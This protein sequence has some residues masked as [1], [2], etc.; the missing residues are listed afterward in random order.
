MSQAQRKAL[1]GQMSPRLGSHRVLTLNEGRGSFGRAKI[2]R[3]GYMGQAEG[4]RLHREA[5]ASLME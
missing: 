1:E 5:S 3:E 2:P 4:S